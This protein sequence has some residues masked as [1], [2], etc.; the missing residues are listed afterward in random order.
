M[1]RPSLYRVVTTALV[2]AG[3]SNVLLARLTTEDAFANTIAAASVLAATVLAAAGVVPKLRGL[4]E[5]AFLLSFVV[6]VAN[7]VEFGLEDNV[8]WESQVRTIGFYAAFAV[9][10]LGG[11]VLMR[12]NAEAE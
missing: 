1:D 6:W 5:E 10:A 3:L 8:R 2:I 12:L 7:A 4:R 11:F 9:L